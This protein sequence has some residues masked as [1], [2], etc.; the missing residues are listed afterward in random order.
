MKHG[1]LFTLHYCDLLLV[2]NSC[3][4]KNTSRTFFFIVVSLQG[5]AY[6]S[7][8]MS[9]SLLIFKTL[10]LSGG[11]HERLMK[12]LNTSSAKMIHKLRRYQIL[13]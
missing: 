3:G 13:T 6:I 1:E 5:R 12:S 11:P 9:A 7:I 10:S 8:G 4:L 2:T